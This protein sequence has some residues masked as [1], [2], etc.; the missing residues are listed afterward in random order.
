MAAV[1][2]S[3]IKTPTLK[4]QRILWG[5]V[6]VIALAGVS[7][8]ISAP[9]NISFLPSLFLRNPLA[10]PVLLMVLLLPRGSSGGL[11]L[12]G[13]ERR[14]RININFHQ[15]PAQPLVPLAPPPLLNRHQPS[16]KR[17]FMGLALALARA[18]K[19]KMHSY[20]GGKRDSQESSNESESDSAHESKNESESGD[21]IDSDSESGDDIESDSESVDN[22]D[23]NSESGD[24]ID[25]DS[26]SVDDID[27][28]SESKAVSD[29]ESEASDPLGRW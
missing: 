22:I 1:K 4:T 7:F 11:L 13:R 10:K 9:T 15:A 14:N 25:S 18:E 12:S 2:P 5:L 19:K 8:S 20:G 23:S 26:E 24:D 17:H 27:S 16:T 6:L 21:D 29:E 28:D 3:Q